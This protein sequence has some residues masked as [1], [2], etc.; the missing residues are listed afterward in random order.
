MTQTLIKIGAESYEAADYTVPSDRTF[1]NAWEANTTSE[2]IS[3]DMEIAKDIWRDKIRRARV[4][5]LEA[6]DTAFMKAL[7]T[8]GDTSQIAADKQALR[9]A[10]AHTDI[11]AAT[12]PAELIAVQPAG[13]TIS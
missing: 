8:S 11:A 3:I 9:D 2:V 7:E 13:L 6:L 12:T 10:P 1:R 5:P 4:K